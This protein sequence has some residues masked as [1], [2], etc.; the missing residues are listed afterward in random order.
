VNVPKASLRGAA[1]E[2]QRAGSLHAEGGPTGV[3]R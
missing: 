1:F 3:C 2:P